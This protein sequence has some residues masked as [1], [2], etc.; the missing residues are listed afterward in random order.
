MPAFTMVT[1]ACFDCTKRTLFFSYHVGMFGKNC[2]VIFFYLQCAWL[3]D[4]MPPAEMAASVTVA[5]NLK[6]EKHE[7]EDESRAEPD[8][9]KTARDLIWDCFVQ[10][11]ILATY[12]IKDKHRPAELQMIKSNTSDHLSH[13]ILTEVT[14]TQNIGEWMNVEFKDTGK[15]ERAIQRIV[16]DRL[17]PECDKPL[18]VA[19]NTT[20]NELTVMLYQLDYSQDAKSGCFLEAL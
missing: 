15:L 7:S 8:K 3:L 11:G 10:V 9:P 1:Q 12:K 13:F 19:P 14:K 6:Q 2:I 17:S 4:Q 16:Y 5:E 20:V 18:T